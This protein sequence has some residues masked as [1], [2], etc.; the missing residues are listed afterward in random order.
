MKSYQFVLQS[1][2]CSNGLVCLA[3]CSVTLVS[4]RSIKIGNHVTFITTLSPLKPHRLDGE[5]IH[6]TSADSLRRMP[7]VSLQVPIEPL[8]PCQLIHMLILHICFT[9]LPHVV[10][11]ILP[12]LSSS[13]S[14]QRCSIMG[15]QRYHQ[16]C[17]VSFLLGLMQDG[18]FG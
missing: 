15:D 4:E 2:A 10:P 17:S 18:E 13:H 12:R 9:V 1:L 8:Q 11:I 5:K 16:C 6:C 14:G 3:C 7:G